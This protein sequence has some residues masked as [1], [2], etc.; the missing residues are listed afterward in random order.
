MELFTLSLLQGGYSRNPCYREAIYKKHIIAGMLRTYSV[1]LGGRSLIPYYKML[2]T[3]S[4]LQGGVRGCPWDPMA[5]HCS[6]WQSMVIGGSPLEP[7]YR[8]AID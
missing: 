4:L 2:F 6:P 5:P 8:E 3:K 1:V 7:Y